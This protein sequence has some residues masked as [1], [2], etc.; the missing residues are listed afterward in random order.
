MNYLFDLH[1]YYLYLACNL[2]SIWQW[3]D[4]YLIET[5]MLVIILYERTTFDYYDHVRRRLNL[6]VFL[7]RMSNNPVSEL[8]NKYKIRKSSHDTMQK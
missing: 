3:Y 8:T 4:A 7:L 6:K 5:D 2:T 1:G